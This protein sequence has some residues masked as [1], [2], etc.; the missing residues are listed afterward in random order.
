MGPISEMRSGRSRLTRLLHDEKQRSGIQVM[1]SLR[2]K[3]SKSL[4]SEKQA[5]P[6]EVTLLGRVKVRSP[7]L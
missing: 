5:V 3:F 2:V 6:I 1:F 4:Q 7:L